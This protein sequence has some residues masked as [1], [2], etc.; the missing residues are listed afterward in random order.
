MTAAALDLHW[1]IACDLDQTLIYSRRAFRLPAG[2]PEPE[3]VV[4]EY[5]DGRPLSHLTRRAVEGLRELASRVPIVPVTTRTQAQYERVHLGFTPAYAIAAN[6]GHLFV[7]GVADAGWSERVRERLAAAGS[8]L[9]EVL[10]RARAIAEQSEADGSGWVRTVRDADGL[11]VYLVATER[12]AIPDLTEL[13][14]ELGLAGWT[15]SVQG[16]KVYLVPQALTKEAAL[17]EVKRRTG[18]DRLAAAGDSL[19]DLGMLAMADV[20]IRPAHGELHE[21]GIDH[22]VRAGRAVP[23][24]VTR[25]PGVLGGEEVVDLLRNTTSHSGDSRNPPVTF[26]VRPG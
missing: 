26:S 3:V 23:L 13:E 16:R 5:L 6:G 12:T 9:L 19:L 20:A 21:Q 25:R 4:V 14:A 15:V 2:E 11:F 1:L 10:A 7:D 8:P 22:V 17:A 24:L 18:A